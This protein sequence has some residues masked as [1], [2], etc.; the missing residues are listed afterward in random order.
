MISA[1]RDCLPDGPQEVDLQFDGGETL[2][3]GQRGGVG[4][5]HR[6]VGPVKVAPVKRAHRIMMPLARLQL[7]YRTPRLDDL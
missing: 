5:D 6:G 3:L 4:Q 2:A 7:E 1:V